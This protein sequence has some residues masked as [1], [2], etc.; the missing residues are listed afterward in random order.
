MNQTTNKGLF[1]TAAAILLAGSLVSARAASIQHGNV[2]GYT[3]AQPQGG[4]EEFNAGFSFYSAVWPL[5]REYYRF[6]K[7]NEQDTGKWI[8]VKG[9]DVPKETGL[10]K[11]SFSRPANERGADLVTPEDPESCWK[12]PGP[13]AGPFKVKL[14]DGSTVTYH[15]YRF[16]DQPSL[17]NADMTD[18][19]RER[20]QR[21]VEKL[22]RHW[23]KDRDYL[24][25]PTVGELADV[26]PA[27]I[28]TPPA[29][30][31]V[32][33]VPITTRQAME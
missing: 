11:V 9:A 24:T 3:R 14:G 1:I 27:Q 30:M 13:A 26:D 22:H 7:E 31:E 25:P 10:A 15:W 17:L 23:H 5:Q 21:R 16:A 8:P 12:T 29:G 18:A 32:G 19:E 4:Q 6:E 28:V 20:L 2:G 33:F